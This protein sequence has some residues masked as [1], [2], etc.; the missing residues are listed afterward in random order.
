MGLLLKLHVAVGPRAFEKGNALSA[1]NP[2]T[3]PRLSDSFRKPSI[4]HPSASAR[5]CPAPMPDEG[6]SQQPSAASTPQGGT[7]RSS[8][9]GGLQE[10]QE[11][12]SAPWEGSRLPGKIQL[13]HRKS[14]VSPTVNSL[15]AGCAS[16]PGPGTAEAVDRNPKN[17]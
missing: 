4:P 1:F 9:P 5:A 10:R 8:P 7:R 6:N 15:D 12:A 16:S 13:T 11:A 17:K 3:F 14:L 2:D